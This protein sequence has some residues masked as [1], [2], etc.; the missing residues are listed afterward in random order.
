MPI[1]RHVVRVKELLDLRDIQHLVWLEAV[2][3]VGNLGR[4]L[5]PVA[6]TRL[7]V[8]VDERGQEVPCQRIGAQD[9]IQ[10]GRQ[11]RLDLPNLR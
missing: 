11:Q 10:I 4:H 3:V 7:N 6:T 2:D 5:G 1:R 9:S 8:Q